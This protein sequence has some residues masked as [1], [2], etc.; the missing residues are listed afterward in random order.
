MAKKGSIDFPP[1]PDK[2]DNPGAIKL[3]FERAE[4]A[5]KAA[6]RAAAEKAF[7]PVGTETD[8]QP[9][10][11][12]GQGAINGTPASEAV[13]KDVAN[14]PSELSA[15][16]GD[17][18]P[19]DVLDLY[20]KLD[21]DFDFDFSPVVH[22]KEEQQSADAAVPAIER[23]PFDPHS[24]PS[25]DESNL[26]ASQYTAN[27]EMQA[28][29][30]A[31]SAR[32]AKNA[33]EAEVQEQINRNRRTRAKGEFIAG[34]TEDIPMADGTPKEWKQ[35][36]RELIGKF[37]GSAKER[38]GGMGER[39]ERLK[40]YL[41][42]R[43]E[44]LRSK[45]EASGLEKGV[46]WAGEVYNKLGWKSKLGVG[47]GLGIGAGASMAF[48]SLPAAAVFFTGIGMQRV[49]GFAGKFLEYEAEREAKTPGEKWGK[50][51]AMWGALKYTALMTAG[52]LA[53]SY[54]VKEA[55]GYAREQGWDDKAI[56]WAKSF[57]SDEKKTVLIQGDRPPAAAIIAEKTAAAHAPATGA[58]SAA[59]PEAA[60]PAPIEMPTV[61]ASAGHGYEYMMKRLWEDLHAKG[62]ELPTNANPDSDLARLLAA[63]EDSIDKLVH[64]MASDSKHQFFRADGLS[65]LITPDA[66]MTIGA[67]GELFL[68]DAGHEYQ[69]APAHAPATPAAF[70]AP[71]VEPQ[72]P[73][74]E[75]LDLYFGTQSAAPQEVNPLTGLVNEQAPAP[76]ETH[77]VTT[78]S[79]IS[80][81]PVKT[82]DLTP[83][84]DA[85]NQ[86]AVETTQTPIME[87]HSTVNSFGVEV[88]VTAPRL[89]ADSADHI[90]AYGGSPVENGKIMLKYL[91]KNP[92]KIIYAADDSGKYRI[93]WHLV[94]GKVVPA[95]A[96]IQTSG[97]FGFFR[98]FM[99][100]PG[101]D[102][103]ERVVNIESTTEA[104]A[105]VAVES[106]APTPEALDAAAA[107]A[108]RA[109][110]EASV[111]ARVAADVKA[112]EAADIVST[113]KAAANAEA[114]R[115]AAEAQSKKIDDVIDAAIRVEA[116]RKQEAADA[117]IRAAARIRK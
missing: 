104:S 33:L 109:Q 114:V 105:N 94:D 106:P 76:V 11:L 63:D 72:A 111:A 32:G 53:L 41:D 65:V 25:V 61:K 103:F 57:W 9:E 38:F 21:G 99:K 7:G 18:I 77:T 113:Q 92:D 59:V 39:G 17:K 64:E 23:I 116:Q 31:L 93:P 101:P 19:T 112:Q 56:E 107:A 58:P 71:H 14:V 84:Q 30:D 82:V 37:D 51:K 28:D 49:A 34:E 26:N 62:V 22:T 48:A 60:A 110:E 117:A 52:M 40:N 44:E 96:P 8:T 69:F 2:D 67:R 13:S 85:A 16:F 115:A 97:F 55:V 86:G 102:E 73:T 66:Q 24:V 6:T 54:G 27:P 45:G 68:S 47:L 1:K 78:E 108:K 29:M 74:P 95:G 42:T 79:I 5:R 12:S 70:A 3:A 20:A 83:A 87:S 80:P 89:Y 50:E 15:I 98:E 100:A 35:K 88:S 90:F 36:L 91:I 81:E 43:L 10:M 75:A 4:E 46:R